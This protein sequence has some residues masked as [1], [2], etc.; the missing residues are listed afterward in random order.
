MRKKATIVLFI[1]LFINALPAFANGNNILRLFHKQ[2]ISKCDNLVLKHAS[3]SADDEK[4]WIGVIRIHGKL[5]L[6]RQLSK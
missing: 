4:K 2:G 5:N 3:I 6:K 1:M